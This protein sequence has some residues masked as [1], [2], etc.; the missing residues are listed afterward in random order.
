MYTPSW[1]RDYGQ[2]QLYL[3]PPTLTRTKNASEDYSG[4]IMQ[5]DFGACKG[6]IHEAEVA[7]SSAKV[8]SDSWP[9]ITNLETEGT[10]SKCL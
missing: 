7:R 9:I 2:G 1:F 5:G 3:L 10:D 8:R 4:D 6:Y